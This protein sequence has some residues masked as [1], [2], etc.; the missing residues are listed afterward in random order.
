MRVQLT[1][2]VSICTVNVGD[3]HL[4]VH[5][6]VAVADVLGVEG[7]FRPGISGWTMTGGHSVEV[8]GDSA[9]LESVLPELAI[10]EITVTT[11]HTSGEPEVST[12]LAVVPIELT[13]NTW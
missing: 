11:V 1:Q 8:R 3:P 10:L 5:D 4:R 2:R 7:T 13:G 12:D 6:G 9:T